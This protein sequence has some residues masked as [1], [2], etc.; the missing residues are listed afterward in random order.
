MKTTKRIAKWL[1][2]FALC[3]AMV[4]SQ[5]PTVFAADDVCILKAYDYMS[6]IAA[7]NTINNV[8]DT[9]NK[10]VIQ[11]NPSGGVLDAEGDTF[12]ITRAGIDVSIEAAPHDD[13]DGDE[14]KT[15][16][17]ATIE[18]NLP[19]GTYSTLRIGCDAVNKCKLIMEGEVRR[20]VIQM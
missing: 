2:S 20:K 16:K 9:Y 5:M 17:N 1:F 7:F 18:I 6:L 15:I 13:N 14:S 19:T 3:V 4:L 12:K 11:I 8:S 10:Y